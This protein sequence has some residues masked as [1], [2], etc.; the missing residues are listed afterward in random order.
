[1]NLH[2]QFLKDEDPDASFLNFVVGIWN[3][4][5]VDKDEKISFEE[6]VTLYNILLDK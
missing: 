5:D 3:T 4:F 6:F 1:M 2:R